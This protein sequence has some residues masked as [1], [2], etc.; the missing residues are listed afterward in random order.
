VIPGE[1]GWLVPPSDA[2]AL[3]EAIRAC[4]DAPVEMLARMGEMARERVLD[5]HDVEKVSEKLT[6]LF[7]GQ[8]SRERIGTARARDLCP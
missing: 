3:A 6:L 1:H 7:Q 2:E 5:R 4:L 8:C